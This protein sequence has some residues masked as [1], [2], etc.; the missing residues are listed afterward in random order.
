MGGVPGREAKV[1][2]S[3]QSYKYISPPLSLLETVYLDAFWEQVCVLYPR[4]LAPNVITLVGFLFISAAFVATLCL[5]PTAEGRIPGWCLLLIAVCG[6]IYQTMDGTDGKQARRLRCG[7]AFGE[8]FDHGCDA[9]TSSMYAIFS[10]EILD[11]G[12]SSK[13]GAI[14]ILNAQLAFYCSNLTLVHLQRQEIRWFDS[15]EMQALVQACGLVKALAPWVLTR[16]ISLPLHGSLSAMVRGTLKSMSAA[17]GTSLTPRVVSVGPSSEQVVQIQVEVRVLCILIGLCAPIQHAISTS[18]RLFGHYWWY[19]ASNKSRANG[20]GVSALVGHISSILSWY[21]AALATHTVCV[22]MSSSTVMVA[23]V[24]IAMLGFGDL[25]NRTL[26]ERVANIPSPSLPELVTLPGPVGLVALASIC[27][28]PNLSTL[29]RPG[30]GGTSAVGVPGIAQ[31][32]AGLTPGVLY[33][34]CLG[35]VLCTAVLYLHYVVATGNTICRALDVCWF[36][37]PT[38]STSTSTRSTTSARLRTRSPSSSNLKT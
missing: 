8:L 6:F 15:Q 18:I 35:A 19:S 34:G 26:V 38:C 5:D 29:G 9:L 33:L 10:A 4:W 12:V 7:S 32:E 27:L 16:S 11:V 37:V 30:G 31:T 25:M 2:E 17:V 24:V 23:W 36:S 1:R 13:V 21:C 14:F 28:S 3:L 20:R 22:A